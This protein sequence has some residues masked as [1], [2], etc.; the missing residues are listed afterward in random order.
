MGDGVDLHDF[1]SL[2]QRR[3]RIVL[4]VMLLALA[5]AAG[6]LLVIKPVYSATALVIVDTS[7]KDLLEPKDQ[8][9]GATADSLRVDSEVELVKSDATL[10]AVAGQLQLESDPEFGRHAGLRDTILS[11]LG[12]ENPAPVDEEALRRHTIDRLRAVVNVQR[13]NLTYLIAVSARSTR[14]ALAADIANAV[15]RSYIQQ[16]LQSKVSSTLGFRDIINARLSDSSDAVFGAEGAFD[17]FIDANLATIARATVRSDT[18]A[19]RSEIGLLLEQRATVAARLKRLEAELQTQHRLA[20]VPVPP[21]RSHGKHDTAGHA[22]VQA[23]PAEPGPGNE[24][25]LVEESIVAAAP[26]EQ[27]ARTLGSLQ[28][29]V[30]SADAAASYLRERLSAAILDSDLPLDIVAGVNELQQRA[31]VARAHHQT[32]LDRQRDLD[33]EAVLQVPDSRVASDAMRPL[34]P[35]FPDPVLFVLVSAL[36]GLFAGTGLAVLAENFIGGFSSKAQAES[37]LRLPVVAAVPRRRAVRKPGSALFTVADALVD[38]PLSDYSEAVRRIR[39]GVDMRLRQARLGGFDGQGTVIAITSAAAEE[40]KSTIALS[41]A[42]AYAQAGSSTVLIDCDLRRPAIHLLLDLEASN[43]LL[44]YLTSTGTAE[45]RSFVTVDQPTGAQVVLGSRRNDAATDHL[46]AGPAFAT[47]IQAARDN[48][49][50]VIL[51][52]PPMGAIVDGL[53]L[54]GMA[55][56]VLLVVKW[57]A[58]PQQEVK[59]A[60]ANLS[61]AM[62]KEAPLMVVLNQQ[63]QASLGAPVF[64]RRDQVEA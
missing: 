12:V 35:A 14:P 53:Y 37:V 54:A 45:L 2:L 28:E 41:L 26:P 7:K 62:R 22:S 27:A 6:A 21:Q 24:N 40:G 36:V 55:D 52:T 49:D 59:S 48:F 56:A 16:Q 8:T 18:A 51:D 60:V 50:V 13:R 61:G 1:M 25:G 63:E 42:R 30:V 19:M 43:G 10:L 33:A 31:D 11:M 38:A 58:T 39:V 20:A 34:R 29:Q 47:L 64:Y 32:L 57:S 46:V 23:F 9:G 15:A 3:F 4:G 44:E 17:R 5:I